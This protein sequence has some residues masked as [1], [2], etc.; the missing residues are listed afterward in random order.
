MEAAD[1]R[2]AIAM[3]VQRWGNRR[4]GVLRLVYARGRENAGSATTAYV[5]VTP[6]A[7]RMLQARASGVSVLTLERGYASDLAEFAPWLLLGAKTLSY[8]VNMAAVRY[9]NDNGADDAVFVSSDGYLL[10]GPRAAVVV[11][12]DGELATPPAE[13]GI[14]PSTTQ[15][16]VFD[17]A[18]QYGFTTA[19]KPLTVVDLLNADGAWM[20][21]SV[22]LS[23]RI[24]SVNGLRMPTPAGESDF[25]RLVERAVERD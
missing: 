12:R 1:W 21:S 3:A 20:L 24:T 15:R 11:L 4:E 13:L 2:D 19:Y 16:A 14:L 10:E 17:I 23:A 9:A 7:H 8:A 18:D 6:L 5:L 25:A 22:T